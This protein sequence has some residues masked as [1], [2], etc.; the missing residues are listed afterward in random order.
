[1]KERNQNSLNPTL[2]FLRENFPNSVVV[3]RN[4]KG[5]IILQTKEISRPAKYY[6][7]LKHRKLI[8]H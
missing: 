1:M 3:T 6:L 8:S 2:S 4:A 5:K 7:P